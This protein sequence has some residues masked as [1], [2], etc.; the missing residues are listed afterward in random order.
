MPLTTY[1]T[2]LPRF[3]DIRNSFKRV[4]V[5]TVNDF[6]LQTNRANPANDYDTWRRDDE[7][8]HVT[9]TKHVLSLE[10]K[11]DTETPLTRDHQWQELRYFWEANKGWKRFVN[12]QYT[13]TIKRRKRRISLN[14]SKHTTQLIT[15]RLIY[16]IGDL[17]R[18]KMI[19]N[20]PSVKYIL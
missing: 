9:C 4:L 13:Y 14:E 3:I 15:N 11:N 8:S 20:T 12:E 19:Y 17:Y 1:M 2:Y 18:S 16:L 10:R 7:S 6:K 5:D